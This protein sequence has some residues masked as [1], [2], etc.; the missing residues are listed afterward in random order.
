MEHLPNA[1]SCWM[2]LQT[3]SN[4]VTSL[5]TNIPMLSSVCCDQQKIPCQSETIFFPSP[6]VRNPKVYSLLPQFVELA[7]CDNLHHLEVVTCSEIYQ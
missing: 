7:V 6:E 1:V 3:K 2:C 4:T 5:V